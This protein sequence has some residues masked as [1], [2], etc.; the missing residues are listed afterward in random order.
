M[1]STAQITVFT[2]DNAPLCKRF[3]L[4]GDTIAKTT[5]ATLY[6]GEAQVAPAATA[7][8]L[9]AIL[10]SLNHRQA[11]AA[12]VLKRGRAT[13]I[14]T[15]TKEGWGSVARSLSNFTFPKG[16]GWLLWDYDDKTMPPEVQ[17]RIDALGGPV[18]AL[19]HIWPEARQA[20]HVIRPSSSDGITAP[21]HA[22]LKSAG[23]HGFFLVQDVSQSRAILGTLEARAWAA[24][25]A[26]VAL[27]KSGALLHR[28]IIDTAVGSP[29]RLIF[30][31]PPILDA[32]VIRLPR[33]AI[34]SEGVAL[35]CPA[36]PLE[37]AA[38]LREAAKDAIKPKAAK[39]QGHYIDTRA[40]VEAEKTGKTFAEARR[41]IVR[42]MHGATLDDD[43]L[44]Q[45]KSGTW[46]SVGALLDAGE[47]VDRLSMPDPVEGIEYGTD[48]ATLLIKPRASNP[49]EKPRL[50]SH[51]HGVTTVYKFA[52]FEP[53]PQPP[54]YPKPEG[55]RTKNIAAHGDTVRG[56]F[57]AH[58]APIQAS[59]AVKEL[60]DEIDE[61]EPDLQRKA[62]QKAAR[63]TMQR[64]MGLDYLPSTHPVYVPEWLRVLLSGAQGV[65]KSAA[66]V[67]DLHKAKLTGRA[68]TPGALHDTGRIVSLIL[69]PDHA[70][71]TELY[72]DY[73]ANITPDSPPP[74]RLMGRSQKDPATGDTLCLIPKAAEK[75]AKKGGN[76]K[77]ALCAQCPYA[78]TCGYLR[79]EDA[80]AR[81]INAGK[82]VAIFAPQDYAFL[83][84]PKNY[85][86]DIVIMDEALRD[87]G[88]ELH[89]I[90]L[91]SLGTPLRAE[92]NGRA[93]SIIGKTAE[94]A[95]AAAANLRYIQPLRVAVRDGFRATPDTPY[96]GFAARGID[97]E[98]VAEAIKAL[99][100]F[101]EQELERS[102]ADTVRQWQFAQMAG[103]NRG[104]SLEG[105]IE[106]AIDEKDTKQAR[107]VKSLFEG[108]LKDLEKGHSTPTAVWRVKDALR[109][110]GLR[111]P[112]FSKKTP[113]LMMDGT[114]APELMQRIFGPLTVHNYAAERTAHVVQTTGNQ[115][116]IGQLTGTNKEGVPISSKSVPEAASLRA[117]VIALADR[118][119]V[120]LIV[121][122]K[123][124]EDAFIADGYTGRTAHY[125]AL[126]GRNDWE[127]CETVII[128]GPEIPP[129]AAIEAKARAYAANDPNAGPF[130]S[131]GAGKWH[132]EARAL[133][134]GHNG[135][136]E[137]IDVSCHPDP[138]AERVLK[139]VRDAE[140]MQAIDRIRLIYNVNP[141]TVI[142]LAPVVL[143]ITVNEV[144]PWAELKTGGTRIERAKAQSGVVPLS[145]HTARDLF[146]SIW[147]S[148]GA[149]QRDTAFIGEMVKS[150]L[151]Q[152]PIS[153]SLIGK[154]SNKSAR[155]IEYKPALKKGQKRAQT[156]RALV[157]A[158][159]A[160]EARAKL[161]SLTGPLQAFAEVA[162]WIEARD[163]L[164]DS[165]DARAERVAI[166][167]IDG[168]LSRAD[169]ER[170]ADGQEL[171][172]IAAKASTDAPLHVVP[173]RIETH[174]PSIGSEPDRKKV[175]A[176]P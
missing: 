176:V 123:R 42:M 171:L 140:I 9:A 109:I 166:A 153:I 20:A 132:K 143:D 161:E 51:A 30:E 77:K 117:S 172:L 126:R 141:K 65:G 114:A 115:F 90:A 40:T 10:D 78:E 160:D 26:W 101:E 83:R 149:A 38:D 142:I 48:K 110:A 32:P 35:P 96:S 36:G 80:L 1:T 136:S 97:A 108:V 130:Q 79:N 64:E 93:S 81:L 12:G 151:D 138:W 125:N 84:L 54:F 87:D 146:P 50:V 45:T 47:K 43:H 162:G 68:G 174:F 67:G 52:R 102:L 135:G 16:K 150:L 33:P 44:L 60:Y 17:A 157:W 24:G 113:L 131:I 22:K 39:V 159:T 2:S 72:D 41:S 94:Q 3:T 66:L 89:R 107:K 8:D 167:E 85:A 34:I 53:A 11:I 103:G 92:D 134:L 175:G 88:T 75:V 163:A 156:H 116:G 104:R 76:V 152:T 144:V 37:Q 158:E 62:L 147:Q 120:P 31:A 15:A 145:K 69:A 95:D 6:A 82:G 57:A 100:L 13:S 5:L 58:I 7:A 154:W 173:F 28:S 74:F 86:P 23:L 55:D 91:E 112:Y 155:L 99:T 133:R 127:Q 119:P 63:A 56:F 121:A 129:P 111:K 164:Q 59:K 106:A 105:T 148:D 73:S 4:K 18:A 122:S 168:G 21:N 170:I 169:A 165:I 70:K 27:S 98:Y 61:T 46:V 25:L 128:A 137:M 118:Y 124:V 71:T 49:T 14:T 29:E 139:Q 19:F